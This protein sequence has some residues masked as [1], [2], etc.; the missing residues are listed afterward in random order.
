MIKSWKPHYI[1]GGLLILTATWLGYFIGYSHTPYDVKTGLLVINGEVFRGQKFLPDHSDDI[2]DFVKTNGRIQV[3][4][5]K[6]IVEEESIQY[7]PANR[8]HLDQVPE[9]TLNKPKAGLWEK[10]A[11]A[12]NVNE[13]NAAGSKSKKH[14]NAK[15]TNEEIDLLPSKLDTNHFAPAEDEGHKESTQ[16]LSIGAIKEIVTEKAK[17]NDYLARQVTQAPVAATLSKACSAKHGE[18]VVN[19]PLH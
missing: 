9:A 4:Y 13:D 5:R 19:N 2:Q 6:K 7:I 15:E 11:K 10:L 14:T 12:K 17:V 1:F 18:T 8:D 16:H 3:R